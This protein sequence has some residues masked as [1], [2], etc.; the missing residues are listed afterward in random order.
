MFGRNSYELALLNVYAP[1]L[2]KQNEQVAFLDT[3][4][5]YVNEY[6]HKIIMAGDFNTYLSN[7][8]KHGNAGKITAYTTRINTLMNELDLCDIFRVF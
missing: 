5:P 8:D 6:S 3:I 1:T 4:I 7:L 2:D